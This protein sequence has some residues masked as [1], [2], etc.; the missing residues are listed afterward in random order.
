MGPIDAAYIGE[1]PGGLEPG[2]IHLEFT[3]GWAAVGWPTDRR[4]CRFVR[5]S[6]MALT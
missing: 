3:V 1:R 6:A 4:S 2:A 5:Q